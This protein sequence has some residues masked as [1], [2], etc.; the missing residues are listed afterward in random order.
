MLSVSSTSVVRLAKL[1]CTDTIVRASSTSSTRPAAE[2]LWDRILAQPERAPELIALAAAERFGPQ[3]EEWVRIAGPGHTPE[4][5]AKVAYRKHVRLARLEGGVLGSA[6]SFTAAP[7][8]VALIWI[9]SRMIFYIAAA[10]GYDPRHPMRPAELLALQG[11][12]ET[13]AEARAALDGIGKLMAQAM[14]EKAISPAAAPTASTAGCSSTSRKRLARRYAGALHPADRRAARRDPERRRHEGGRPARAGVL[15]RDAGRLDR[16]RGAARRPRL[17]GDEEAHD[18]RDLRRRDPLRVVGVGHAPRGWRGVD[19]ARQDRVAA[20][21]VR[22]Y[23]ASSAWTKAS[24]A[25]LAV[26]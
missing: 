19:H 5:L 9:Q 21:A 14:V 13:P 4:Q 17:L 1:P 18:L 16:H 6:A 15:R 2:S 24:T 7:D 11:V 12:Y 22:A 8:M 26:M 25:A 23:S 20:D 10:Y 3:A